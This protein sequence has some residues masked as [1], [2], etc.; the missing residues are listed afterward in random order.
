MSAYM[1][2]IISMTSAKV[3][4]AMWME[5]GEPLVDVVGDGGVVSGSMG[6]TG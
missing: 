1:A 5:G 4:S 6:R 3:G 2:F